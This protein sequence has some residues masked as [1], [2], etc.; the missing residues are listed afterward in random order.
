MILET[1]EMWKTERERLPYSADR[2]SI[3]ETISAKPRA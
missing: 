3:N 2:G 1:L